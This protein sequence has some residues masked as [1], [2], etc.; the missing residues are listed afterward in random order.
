MRWSHLILTKAYL[1]IPQSGMMSNS[2]GDSRPPLALFL[3]VWP[4]LHPMP[5]PLQ[6][7]KVSQALILWVRFISAVG[8]IH[9]VTL[10]VLVVWYEEFCRRGYGW[11]VA[12]LELESSTANVERRAQ[13]LACRRPGIRS[14]CGRQTSPAGMDVCWGCLLIT[15]KNG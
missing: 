10:R 6:G 9:M 5:V 13:R 11:V 3:L 15:A 12:E 14:Y 4:H 1:R 2:K 8:Y 7:M